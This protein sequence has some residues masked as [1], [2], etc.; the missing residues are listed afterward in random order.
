M[1]SLQLNAVNA[2]TSEG[3]KCYC[4]KNFFHQSAMHKFIVVNLNWSMTSNECIERHLFTWSRNTRSVKSA[5]GM[6]EATITQVGI[7]KSGTCQRR[8]E[9]VENVD[10][11]DISGSGMKGKSWWYADDMIRIAKG[12]PKSERVFRNDLRRNLE[13]LSCKISIK[14]SYYTICHMAIQNN[15]NL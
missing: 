14:M 4:Y 2:I 3:Y 12:G 11:I 8:P 6:I 1:E 10:G 9:V 5:A 13:F 7:L 15:L